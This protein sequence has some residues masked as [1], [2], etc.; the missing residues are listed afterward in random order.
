MALPRKKSWRRHCSVLLRRH[1]ECTYHSVL[2]RRHIE[3]TCHIVLLRA[4]VRTESADWTQQNA[5]HVGRSYAR[6]VCAACSNNEQIFFTTFEC[7]K[8]V[9]NKKPRRL[10]RTLGWNIDDTFLFQKGPGPVSQGPFWSGLPKK[11][12]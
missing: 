4:E 7:V 1:S 8:K 9:T 3:W 12:R 2:Q 11:P 10:I 5:G 6:T